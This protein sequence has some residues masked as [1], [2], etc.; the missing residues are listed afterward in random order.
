M[1]INLQNQSEG[2]Q[3]TG[4]ALNDTLTGGNGN[5]SITGGGGTDSIVGGNGNDTL[6]GGGGADLL[7]GGAGADIFV[8]TAT[9]DSPTGSRDTVFDFTHSQNDRIDL[10]LIDAVSGGGDNAFKL[11]SAFTHVAG[12]LISVVEADHYVVQ[13]DINGDGLA[14]FAINVFSSTALTS[15]DFI[16]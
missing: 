2:F 9:G 13:G 3:I 15:S 12:Q 7:R 1:A 4:S 8:F 11:V 14:D 5:D 6:V 10:H 16:L